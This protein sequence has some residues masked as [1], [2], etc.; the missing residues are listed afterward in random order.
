MAETFVTGTGSTISIGRELG[1]GGEGTVYEVLSDQRAVAKLY[2]AQHMPDALKQDKLRFMAA[3]ADQEL[4]SYAAWP[5][6]TLHKT[7]GGPVIG[8]LMP[9][10]SGCAPIHMLYSPAHRRQDYPQ[11]AWDFL[12]FAARNTAAAFA[13]LHNHGHV[14]GDVNQGNL[15]VMAD[16]KV[17]LIDT[18]SFQIDANGTVHLCQVGVSHFTP[19]ELH[20]V[21]FD[22]VARTSNHD[23]FGLALLVFHLLFG[24]RHPYSGVPLRDD[25]GVALEKDIQSFRYAYAPD[26]QQ[27]GFRPPPKSIS[28]DI[29]PGSIQT[30]FMAAFT[31]KGRDVGRPT[32]QQWVTALD[33]VRGQLKR[34]GITPM[35][36]HPG[37]L[38]RCPWCAL[39]KQG[40]V[41]FLD[42][43]AHPMGG[44]G[45][46]LASVWARIEAISVPPGMSIPNVASITVTPAPLPSVLSIRH[47]PLLIL[48]LLLF[49]GLPWFLV[50]HPPD[51]TLLAKLILFPFVLLLLA[52]LLK[53]DLPS[54]PGAEREAERAK[55]QAAQDKAQR[56]YDQIVAQM[57][58]MTEAFHKNKQGLAH[59]RDEYRR[60]LEREEAEIA[61]LYAAASLHAVTKDRQRQQ[62][63]ENCFIDAAS[64]P[65][66]NPTRKAA[67]QSFGIETAADVTW[68]KVI[69][70]R[71]FGKNLRQAVMKWRRACES[72][73]VFDPRLAVTKADKN[74][75]R[76]RLAARKRALEIKLTAGVAELQRLRQ[77]TVNKANTLRPLL[78]EASQNLAQARADLS[79]CH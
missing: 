48:L 32:A 4:L 20:G 45:F 54:S 9:K 18:D 72:K 36:V 1:R 30:M 15:L 26:A 39:E 42:V 77:E 64:I 71:G 8:F 68:E 60:L 51:Y 61:T 12:L 6:D 58:R 3:S 49:F 44:A 59:L 34:C 14:V 46:S 66:I 53:L 62:F 33:N 67:L 79:V 50:Y 25:V 69:A 56:K 24:G 47:I 29:V 11:A 17:V 28:V 55:R 23:N 40:L 65:G 52:K 31:E 19:P 70:M 73:F 2:N 38:D 5:Q 16:S 74:A 35:H 27:R 10:I 78:Q 43:Q 21:P 22:R 63:L 37:H 41:Y 76:A 13:T 7:H 57:R 75:V